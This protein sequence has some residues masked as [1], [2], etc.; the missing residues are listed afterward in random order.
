MT[1]Q[2]Q[3]GLSEGELESLT[4]DDKRW[5]DVAKQFAAV[6]LRLSSQDV[7]IDG[8]GVKIDALTTVIEKISEDTGAMR[9]AWNEGVATKRF[10]CRLAQGWEFML[11]KVCIPLGITLIVWAV[12][13]AILYGSP[14]PDWLGALIKIL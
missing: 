11:K 1:D 13:R 7:V 10:F 5:K 8:Q 4:T 12:G 2:E 6:N 9:A 14:I 3:P